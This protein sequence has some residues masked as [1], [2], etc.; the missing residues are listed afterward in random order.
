MLTR[1]PTTENQGQFK[2]KYARDRLSVL[3]CTN[4]DIEKLEIKMK[5]TGERRR[6][7]LKNTEMDLFS[8]VARALV[9]I[10]AN[11][12]VNG[13][14]R[15]VGF[16]YAKRERNH[17]EQPSAFPSSMREFVTTHMMHLMSISFEGFV[18]KNVSFSPK[19][20]AK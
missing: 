4:L 19:A 7:N 12:N 3:Q 6:I 15:A 17:C 10:Q 16:S 1:T 8:S 2:T 20:L 5:G 14:L 18:Q 11:G 9:R 13:T